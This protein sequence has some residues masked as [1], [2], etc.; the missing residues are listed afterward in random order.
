LGL[1]I[2]FIFIHQKRQ[3]NKSKNGSTDT[4]KTNSEQFHS[5]RVSDTNSCFYYP[6]NQH[7]GLYYNDETT[8]IYTIQGKKFV[9]LRNL[10]C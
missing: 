4:L 7:R 6:N 8:G 2:L 9:F 3:K 1:I 5:V 10:N